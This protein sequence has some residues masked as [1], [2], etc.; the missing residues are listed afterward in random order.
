MSGTCCCGCCSAGKGTLA[1]GIFYIALYALSILANS[2]KIID[3]LDNSNSNYTS[4][5]INDSNSNY[6]SDLIEDSNSNDTTDAGHPLISHHDKTNIVFNVQMAQHSIRIIAAGV[7]LIFTCVMLHGY[8]KRNHR[9]IKPWLIWSY[10]LILVGMTASVVTFGTMTLNGLPL[11]G[12]CT[13]VIFGSFLAM[14][15]Y[16][17]VVVRRFVD[18]LKSEEMGGHQNYKI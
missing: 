16:F 8:R 4:D 7:S 15:I 18:E 1:I 10:V 11:V 13:L 12:F 17:V 5:L 14:Q 9:L 2:S 3:L 6:T